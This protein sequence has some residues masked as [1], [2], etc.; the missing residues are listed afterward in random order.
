MDGRT[1]V[2]AR[3]E[4]QVRLTGRFTVYRRENHN[5]V[6]LFHCRPDFI[7]LI[8]PPGRGELDSSA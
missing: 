7:G 8:V 5:S 6:R 3:D 4:L 2:Y 1:D